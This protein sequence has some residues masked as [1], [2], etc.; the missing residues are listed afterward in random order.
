MWATHETSVRSDDD[1]SLILVP[2][3]A[4][5]T[6]GLELWNST[7]CASGSFYGTGYYGGVRE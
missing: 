5:L 4:K 7:P 6:L 1:A 2:L 3:G